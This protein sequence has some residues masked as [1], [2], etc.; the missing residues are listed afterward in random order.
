MDVSHW[1]L[2]RSLGRENRSTSKSIRTWMGYFNGWLQHD[3]GKVDSYRA[4]C[5]NCGAQV[6]LDPKRKKEDTSRKLKSEQDNYWHRVSMVFQVGENH[7]ARRRGKCQTLDLTKEQRNPQTPE[8]PRM[9]WQ[10][11]ANLIGG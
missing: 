4:R 1:E 7:A 11:D 9:T 5:N 8:R 3:V 2:R 10:I 6:V